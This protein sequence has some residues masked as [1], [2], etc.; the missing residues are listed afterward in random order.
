MPVGSM[1]AS[2]A[3]LSVRKLWVQPMPSHELQD[4]GLVKAIR[5]HVAEGLGSID[6]QTPRPDCMA[7]LFIIAQGPLGTHKFG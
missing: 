7:A 1:S 3:W 5:G 6:E 2:V 4:A